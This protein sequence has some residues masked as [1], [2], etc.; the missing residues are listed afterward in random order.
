[1]IQACKVDLLSLAGNPLA[2]ADQH[3]VLAGE[4][5]QGGREKTI[6]F[7]RAAFLFSGIN[8]SERS[9]D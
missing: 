6:A 7:S 9:N 3:G 8:Q 4:E 5:K 2:G 1:L